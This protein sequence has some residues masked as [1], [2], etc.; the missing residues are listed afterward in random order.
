M[1]YTVAFAIGLIMVG[2]SIFK[3]RESLKFLKYS[4]RA[5]GVIT[6]IQKIEDGDNDSYK[7]YFTFTTADGQEVIYKHNFSGNIT[8]WS[9]GDKG[10]IAYSPYNPEIAKLVSYWGMFSWSI[11]LMALAMPLI[12]VS[13][14]FYLAQFVLK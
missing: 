12:V 13:V 7:P 6:R 14:G 8:T 10:I 5:E 2:I 4:D 9:I 11:V 1:A 3:C